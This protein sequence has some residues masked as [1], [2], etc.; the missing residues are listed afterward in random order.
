MKSWNIEV[1]SERKQREL[2]KT[3][4]EELSIEA[5]TV[6]FSFN[7]GRRMQES[8]PAPLA[9]VEDLQSFIFHLLE[10]KER[11]RLIIFKRTT[12]LSFHTLQT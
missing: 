5:E 6:P 7:I 8:R 1:A 10:E 2:M 12:L 3:S 4:L 9:Y 11:L